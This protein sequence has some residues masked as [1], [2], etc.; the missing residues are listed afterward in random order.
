MNKQTARILKELNNRF[1]QENARSFSSTRHASWAGWERAMDELGVEKTP[2]SVCDLAC[3]NMRFEAF[4]AQ[5]FAGQEIRANC[6]DNCSSLA[7]QLDLPSTVSTSFVKRDLVELLLEE[8]ALGIPRCQLAVCFGF[9]HH[10]PGFEHRKALL[11]QL[12][13]SVEPGGTLAVSF[14]QFLEEEG[15]AQRAVESTAR[16]LDE[17]GLEAGAL[18][19]GDCIL[20]WQGTQGAW[21]YCHSFSAREVELL[22]GRALQASG[23]SAELGFF[24]A[25]GRNGRLNRYLVAR[26]R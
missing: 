4:L 3:G 24:E 9:M 16:A 18:D 7:A 23:R 1:Y 13:E 21:R 14:W 19:E 11:Q 26:V 20:G 5:R 2:R 15:L 17:L 10:V 22:A 8:R 12:V 6:I 25:D